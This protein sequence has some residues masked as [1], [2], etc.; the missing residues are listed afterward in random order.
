M[1]QIVDKVDSIPVSERLWCLKFTLLEVLTIQKRTLIR[2]FLFC[3]LS[4]FFANST[5]SRHGLEKGLLQAW[6]KDERFASPLELL[7]GC[8]LCELI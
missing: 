6:H 7:L 8:D 1:I 2:T 3:V 5:N 4:L